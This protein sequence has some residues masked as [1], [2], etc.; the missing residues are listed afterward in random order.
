MFVGIVSSIIASMFSGLGPALVVAGIF[1][2]ILL[3]VSVKDK[4]GQSALGRTVV[5]VN[6]WRTKSKGANIYRSGPIG[7]AKWGTFQLPGLAAASQLTEHE[8][9]HGR[10]FALISTPAT[11]HFT[12][13]LATEPDGAAL[14]D[15]EQINNQVAEYGI[16]LAN[17]GDEP[18]IEAAS[19]TVET[20]PDTGT[21]LRGEVEGSMDP[22]APLFAR[23][24]LS[25]VVETYPVGSAT[26]RAYIALTFTANARINGKRRNAQEVASDL[27]ARIPGL[28]SSLAATGAGAARPLGAQE[29]CEVIRTA[30][31]PDAAVLI[32]QARAEGETADLS[33]TDVGPAAAEAHWDSYRHDGAV[34]TSW[35]MT[36]PPRG[37][38]QAGILARLLA[39]HRDIARKRVT[40]L[41]RPIDPARAAALVEADLNAAQFNSSA[42]TKPTARSTLSTRSAQATAAEEA[43][44]AGLMN[45]GLIVTA[46]TM[47]RTQEPEARAAVDS[48]TS[49]ARLRMRP[50]FGSQD[51][52]FAAALP[53]GLVLPRHLRIPN[54][55]REAL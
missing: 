54:E 37:V 46:T 52:A 55:V 50:A 25:E 7:R 5:R 39:P 23:A 6:W 20:A 35:T 51:S 8:D 45:F 12:I 27:S 1:G 2:G 28:T 48:L 38:V 36:A 19:V 13:V 18:G 4:H 21:R 43:A 30:Y 3:S 44:G 14:V 47:Q 33:W 31:D 29:I 49:A 22:D 32:D 16:W 17:L 42:S 9:S 53:L 10:R 40:L 34:S 24:M 15:Q 41:Y 26:I 11:R